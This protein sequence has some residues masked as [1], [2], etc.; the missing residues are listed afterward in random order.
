MF[1][2]EFKR[3][4]TSIPYAIHRSQTQKGEKVLLA[5]RH[6]ET[7]VIL[8]LRGGGTFTVNSQSYE[9]NEGDLLLIEPYALHRAVMQEGAPSCYDCICFDLSLLCDGTLREGLESGA[10]LPLRHLPC[11]EASSLSHH[12]KHSLQ[13]FREQKEGWELATAGHLSLFFGALKARGFFLPVLRHPALHRFGMQAMKFI[14]D[15]FAEP[16]TSRHAAEAAHLSHGHFCR[17]FQTVFGTAFCDY[18][19]AYRA[20]RARI[21]L[22]ETNL[23]VGQIALE[24]GFSSCSYFSKVFRQIY[25]K[26]PLSYRKENR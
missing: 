20:E 14:E 8:M 6:K 10:L 11:V 7:E 25:G 17:S 1:R 26:P 4:Y 13:A 23:S 22:K 2:D 5:H 9:V 16:V 19:S 3:R 15:H 21:A 18:L 24:H 12:L